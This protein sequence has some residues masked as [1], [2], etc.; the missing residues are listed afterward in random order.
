[1]DSLMTAAAEALAAGD[2]LGALNRI[3]L[4]NDAPSLAL[5]GIAMAQLGDLARAKALL[6]RAAR[7][8]APREVV[9]RARCIV[10]EAEIAL[11]SRDL[12]FSTKALEEARAILEQHGDV[13]NAALARQLEMRRLLLIGH[14]DETSRKIAKVDVSLLPPALRATHYLAVAGIAMRRLRSAEAKSALVDAKRAADRSGIEP[15][16]AEVE[17]AHRLLVTPTARCIA[18]GEERLL[19]LED[20]EALLASGSL[21][22]DATRYA[23]RSA[24]MLVPLASRPVLFALVRLLAEAWPHDVPRARLIAGGF[25]ARHADESHRVRL[26]VEMARLRAALRPIADV[27][28]TKDGFILQPQGECEVAVLAGPV[29]EAHPS[30]LA[31]LADGEAWSSSALAMALGG[32]QRTMQRALEELH[33]RGKVQ[34]FGKGRARRWMTAPLPGITTTLLLPAAARGR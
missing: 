17:A 34:S 15:L 22:V 16:V 19:R 12:G 8:F 13:V 31:C 29:E 25:A 2:P 7:A 24:T 30:I 5:R 6:K 4:R 21:V 9:A 20:I 14:L 32:S 33:A 1:M 18:Q 27:N 11:V 3:A 10:A 28:A 23:V 26:R